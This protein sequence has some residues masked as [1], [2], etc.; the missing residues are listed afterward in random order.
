MGKGG[1]SDNP[2]ERYCWEVARV[3]KQKIKF[4]SLACDDDHS[5][6]GFVTEDGRTIWLTEK[7]HTAG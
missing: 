5:H 7:E 2:A 4:E 1:L 6:K 3:T